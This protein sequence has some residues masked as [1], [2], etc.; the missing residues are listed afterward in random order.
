MNSI[1]D[2]FQSKLAVI[3]NENKSAL[4]NLQQEQTRKDKESKR[5]EEK[6][7]RLDEELNDNADND[8]NYD[9]PNDDSDDNND[10]NYDSE[11]SD[12][13][14]DDN[15]A[16]IMTRQQEKKQK[17]EQGRQME[18]ELTKMPAELKHNTDKVLNYNSPKVTADNNGINYDSLDNE[19][20]NDNDD[21]NDLNYDSECNSNE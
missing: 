9:S 18:G 5:L 6:L 13:A 12:D 8:L 20:N 17:V 3:E 2:G 4:L 21:S 1:Q 7:K 16:T 11:C 10:I 15:R 19:D 14:K